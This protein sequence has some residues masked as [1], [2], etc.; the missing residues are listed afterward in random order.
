MNE[1]LK[2]ITIVLVSYKS[3]T[4]L[5][6]FIK[7][8][9][10][11][12]PILIIDNLKD[13]ELK[14][15]FKKKINVKIL[16]KKN[17]GYGSS[18]N[19]ASRRIKTKYFFVV[20]PDVTGINSNALN[21]FYKFAKKINDQ[22]SVIGPHFLNV[23]KSGHFQTSLNYKIKEIHN[24]HGSVMFFNKRIFI[25]NKGFD[26]NFFLY[27]EETDYTKRNWKSGLPAYQLNLVKVTHEKGRAVETT[28][29]Q[30]REKLD[31]LYTWHFIWSKFYFFTKHY[32]KI[33]SLLYFIPTLIRIL[34]RIIIYK[35]NNPAKHKKYLCR[36]DGLKASII[37]RKS[38][39]R[40]NNL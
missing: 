28:T 29:V 19:Y 26:E 3:R 31:Y 40:L 15:V 14:K 37:G 25:K 11:V 16:F 24:V 13:Y 18:I 2:D 33:F 9:S 22:F 20:Q 17:D 8:I 36:L 23:A 5:I 4:K 30:D 1:S 39:L 27:W 38:Y 7:K 10:S 12:T 34:F 35:N 6:K 32:G 21:L